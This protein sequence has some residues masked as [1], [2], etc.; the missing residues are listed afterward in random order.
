MASGGG[1]NVP[2]SESHW[3]ARDPKVGW[4][5][6]SQKDEGHRKRLHLMLT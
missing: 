2:G 5:V 6:N 4:E 3:E 1:R